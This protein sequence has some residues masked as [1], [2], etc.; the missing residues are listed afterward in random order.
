MN[1]L[2]ILDYSSIILGSML[3]IGFLSIPLVFLFMVYLRFTKGEWRW[4]YFKFSLLFFTV[5]VVIYF[6]AGLAIRY[7]VTPAQMYAALSEADPALAEHFHLGAT[8]AE[9]PSKNE[10]IRIAKDFDLRE[11]TNPTQS[12]QVAI[13]SVNQALDSFKLLNISG[14]GFERAGLKSGDSVKLINNRPIAVY[15]TLARLHKA[16]SPKITNA[17]IDVIQEELKNA[18]A[19]DVTVSRLQ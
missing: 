2:D 5:P 18:G 14:T 11:G 7:F 8:S 10:V 15:P 1:I 12:I 9:K 17:L 19:C 13:I 6:S 16:G 3:L 4:R